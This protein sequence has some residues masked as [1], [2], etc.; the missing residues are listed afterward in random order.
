MPRRT[1]KNV[2]MH[3]CWTFGVGCIIAAIWLTAYMW[4]LLLTA[5]ILLIVAV[6]IGSLIAYPKGIK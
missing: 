1:W 6:V 4:Q 5:F 2:F 3:A